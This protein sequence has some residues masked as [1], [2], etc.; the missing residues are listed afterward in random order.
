MKKA[1]YRLLILAIL[2]GAGYAGYRYYKQMPT[3]QDNSVPTT[4][5]MKG[6]VVIRAFSRGELHAIRVEP[7]YAPNLNGTV[8][9]TQL[10]PV[11]AFAKAKDLVVEYDDSERLA[12]LEE[13]QLEVQS[14][15]ENIKKA[16][17]ELAIQ[18]S[19]DKVTLLKTQYDVRRAELEVKK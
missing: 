10:A 19:Q 7:L 5:V 4:K 6:D 3:R 1:I 16:K 18:Q 9:V 13:A 12:A 2:G 14:V 11:G 15:D 17:T 8:Q